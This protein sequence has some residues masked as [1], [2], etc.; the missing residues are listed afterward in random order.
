[1]LATRER[2]NDDTGV[3][4]TTIGRPSRVM[5]RARQSRSGVNRQG[6]GGYFQK[7]D[8]HFGGQFPY[9]ALFWPAFAALS[10]GEAASSIAA[11]FLGLDDDR[12]A[13]EPAGATPSKIALEL[14]TV[15]LRD[16]CVAESGVPTLLCTPLALHG[17]TVADLAT[18]HSLV[19]ALR[20]AGIERL[21]MADWRSASA[22]MRYLGIDDY[23]ADLNVLVDEVGGL[24]DFVGL[25]QGGWLSLV[26]TARFPTKV[27]KLV[28]AGTP[29]DIAAG[30]SELSAVAVATPFA[31]FESLV[32]LGNGR[33]IGRNVAKFWGSDTVAVNHMR[34]S[35]Q[36]LQPEGSAEWARLEATFR[37]W[38]SWTID[39][40]GN[41]YL[42]VI[43]K[44]YKRN[45]LA[46]GGFVAL[47]QKIDLSRLR[48]PMYLLAGSDDEVVA[49]E[50]LLA[51]QRLVAT[52]AEHIR[53]DIAPS[54]HLGLFM[55]KRIL[56]EYW[57]GIVRWMTTPEGNSRRV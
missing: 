54:D 48:H 17:S 29:V 8:K 21:F 40:P 10:A 3:A 1:M 2:E 16:F 6:Q 57:P 9:A 11:Q 14:N 18:G 47:G 38:N 52:R 27:R 34:R 35:L 42:E 22:D 39:V 41:Y 31:M 15:R 26:Y 51:V 4:V 30:Q 32:G 12:A 44:L 36:T 37:K 43:E 33:V 49:P 53:H 46:T 25:C 45:E 19:A 56:E 50:Q 20:G 55:G 7:M 13:Q 5:T 24:V 28:M 23:L